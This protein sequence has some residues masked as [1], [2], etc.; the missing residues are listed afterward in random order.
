MFQLIL[1]GNLAEGVTLAQDVQTD[2]SRSHLYARLCSES[3]EKH[4]LPTRPDRA[5]ALVF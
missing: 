4:K 1:N 2:L 5:I 3:E